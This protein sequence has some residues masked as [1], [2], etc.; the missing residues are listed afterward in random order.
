MRSESGIWE[1]IAS[2]LL[3]TPH[4]CQTKY[5]KSVP[6]DK[7]IRKVPKASRRPNSAVFSGHRDFLGRS[8]WSP[9]LDEK[10]KALR[11]QRLAWSDIAL[12]FQNKTRDACARRYYQLVQP[13]ERTSGGRTWTTADEKQLEDEHDKELRWD[14]IGKNMNRTARACYTQYRIKHPSSKAPTYQGP[15][16]FP[17]RVVTTRRYGLCTTN[18]LFVHH[19][20]KE[21][22]QTAAALCKYRG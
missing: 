8:S 9:E 2:Q 12:S 18:L 16:T 3:R 4:A 14:A 21:T 11:K 5:L 6:K 7:Q 19:P 13:G 10:L 22:V 1:D 20:I 17:F 15:A